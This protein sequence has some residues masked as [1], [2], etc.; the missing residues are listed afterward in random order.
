M[1]IFLAVLLFVSLNY[2]FARPAGEARQLV[3]SILQFNGISDPFFFWMILTTPF[4]NKIN[5][6]G[7]VSIQCGNKTYKASDL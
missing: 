6:C 4:R 2:T 3:H 5:L 7:L 1:K